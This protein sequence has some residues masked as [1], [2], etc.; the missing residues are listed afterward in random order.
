MTP[1]K[2]G[3]NGPTAH[4]RQSIGAKIMTSLRPALAEPIMI[5]KKDHRTA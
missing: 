2:H 3:N 1:K 5:L 4:H